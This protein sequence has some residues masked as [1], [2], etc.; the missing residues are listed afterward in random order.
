MIKFIR[1]LSLAYLHNEAKK[2]LLDAIIS[3]S[4]S[5]KAGWEDRAFLLSQTYRNISK[6]GE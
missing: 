2:Q 5:H 4:N 3:A 6:W 1:D